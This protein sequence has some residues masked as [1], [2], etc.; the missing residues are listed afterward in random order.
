V[1]TRSLIERAQR[2]D[3]V[4]LV[5]A[6]AVMAILFTMSVSMITFT[7]ATARD[8]S[9]QDSRQQAQALAEAG[10]AQA[11]AQL[12]SHYYD[13]AKKPVNGSTVF[14]PAWFTGGPASQESPTSTAACAATSTCMSWSVES[15]SF[16]SVIAGCSTTGGSGGVMQGTVV[17]KGTGT[18]PNPTGG[19]AIV[20]SVTTKVDVSQPPQLMDTPSYWRQIY[21]GAPRT[22]GCDLTLGQSVSINAPLYVAGNLCLTSSGEVYGA[23]TDVK[24]LGW[25]WLRQQSRIGTQGNNPER[26]NSARIAG[27]CSNANVAPTMLTGCTINQPGG[28]IW[29]NS[30]TSAHAAGAPT[31]DPLPT[32]EWTKIQTLQAN[33]S[34]A[35]LCTN[36][37]SLNEVS[38]AL[39]PNQSY[40][41]TSAVGSI[42]YT[43]NPAGTSTLALSGN[44]Y[45]SGNLAIATTGLV[46]ITGVASVFVAG[47]VTTANNS[48]LCVK[49]ANGTCDFANATN[50]GSSGE[51]KPT[52][53]I[54]LI[55]SQG[56][57]NAT[58]LRFQ[59]G[60]YS[61]TSISLGGGQGATQGPLVTP[62][63]LTIGQQL[64]GTFPTFPFVIGGTL[65]TILP[66][67]LSS[68]YGGTY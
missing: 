39:T 29:D 10:A 20:R 64:H 52:E 48:Y 26:V 31:P 12:A 15:C 17:L 4:A 36:G 11:L 58:N 6:I 25:V 7:S 37:R 41:C 27:G 55:Q 40:S 59:G 16:W 28:A 35:A 2:E 32:I 23:S 30:P 65:G 66:Y 57:F 54:L 47:A 3:G 51:W 1:T 67:I 49:I 24:V 9:L 56:A 44:I 46:Q 61:A 19:S 60:I 18:V 50:A 13:S 53:T 21:A 43:R 68:P 14:S 62:G 34:P 33:S 63:T 42:T 38:F 5:A 22:N 8:A 45:F